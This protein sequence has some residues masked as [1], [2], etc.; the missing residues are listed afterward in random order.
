VITR[1]LSDFEADG[2]ITTSRGRIRILQAEALRLRGAPY[3][4]V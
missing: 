3:S 1:I 4:A 2:L